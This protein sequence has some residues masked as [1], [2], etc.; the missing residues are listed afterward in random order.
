MDSGNTYTI[1]K[2]TKRYIRMIN[3][4]FQYELSTCINTYNN[5]IHTIYNFNILIENEYLMK[6]LYIIYNILKKHEYIIN[7]IGL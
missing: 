3:L 2:L 7:I 6:Q 5:K 1:C 4:D